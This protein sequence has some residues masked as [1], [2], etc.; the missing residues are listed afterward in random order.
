M[1]NQNSIPLTHP[2]AIRRSGGRNDV[3]TIEGSIVLESVPGLEIVVEHS[4][5]KRQRYPQLTRE[6]VVRL[7]SNMCRM[8]GMVKSMS[9][10]RMNAECYNSRL[11]SQSSTVSYHVLAP[12][13]WYEFYAGMKVETIIH[14]WLRVVTAVPFVMQ[15]RLNNRRRREKR[16]GQPIEQQ[17]QHQGFSKIQ[18]HVVRGLRIDGSYTVRTRNNVV[19]RNSGAIADFVIYKRDA[20]GNPMTGP[21]DPIVILEVSF[22]CFLFL[23]FHLFL[24]DHLLKKPVKTGG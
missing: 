23:F 16:S 5:Q 13:D 11:S 6:V 15:A 24:T 1:G 8:T 19:T 10:R 12:L 17:Q 21:L 2:R 18:A 4:V 7:D 14:D 3:R 20:D 22:S 9:M